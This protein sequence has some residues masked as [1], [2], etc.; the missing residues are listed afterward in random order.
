[1]VLMIAASLLLRGLY[2]AQT[3]E[4]GFRYEEVAVAAFD[5]PGSGY[6]EERGTVFQRELM[7]RVRAL[8]GVQGVAQAQRTPLAEGRTQAPCGTSYKTQPSPRLCRSA[9]SEVFSQ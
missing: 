2:E 8:P 1:M 3:I 6:D 7:R 4:P 5:L 9:E